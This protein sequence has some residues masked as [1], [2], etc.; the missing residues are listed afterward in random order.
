MNKLLLLWF[1]HLVRPV[2]TSVGC[3][4]NINCET[5]GAMPSPWNE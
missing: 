1:A 5:Y 3:Q 4:V 2:L